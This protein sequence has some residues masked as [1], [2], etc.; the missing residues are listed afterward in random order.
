MK[1]YAQ[2]RMAESLLVFLAG[3]D[4]RASSARWHRC[5]ANRELGP[6]ELI[7]PK[8]PEADDIRIALNHIDDNHLGIPPKLNTHRHLARSSR[9]TDPPAR[10]DDACRKQQL[11]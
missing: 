11:A 8:S 10:E 9:P 3:S 1:T 6:T 2:T 5:C 4:K 7:E